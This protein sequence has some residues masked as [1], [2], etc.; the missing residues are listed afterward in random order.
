MRKIILTIFTFL[1]AISYS[2]TWVLQNSNVSVSLQKIFFVDSLHGWSVGNTGTI[3]RS[4]DGGANWI[5]ANSGVSTT[6]NGVHFINPSVGWVV[7]NGGVILKTTNGG[8]SW[9]SQNST[10]TNRLAN[11]FFTDSLNGW[12]NDIYFNI[13]KTTNSGVTWTQYSVG[14]SCGTNNAI[15]EFAFTST[16]NGFFLTGCGNISS[17]IAQTTNGGVTWN[18][19]AP[20]ITQPQA[21][22]FAP[23]KRD[24]YIFPATSVSG[25]TGLITSDSGAT[26]SLLP[27]AT[28]LQTTDVSC[29]SHSVAYVSGHY[30]NATGNVYKTTDAGQT[31]SATFTST[32]SKKNSVAFTDTNHGWCCDAD[33]NIWRWDNSSATIS[34]PIKYLCKGSFASIPFTVQGNFV[35][36]NIFKLYLSNQTG[37]FS[38]ASLIDSITTTTSGTFHPFISASLLNGTGYKLRITGSNPPYSHDYDSSITIETITGNFTASQT[39]LT[40]PQ[41]TAQ[42]NNSSVNANWNYTWL[43]GDSSSPYS[44]N[45]STVYHTYSDNGLFDVSLIITNAGGCSDTVTKSGYIYSTGIPTGVVNNFLDAI[46]VYPNPFSDNINVTFTNDTKTLTHVKLFNVTGEVVKQK[47]VEKQSGISSVSFNASD[48]TRGM[49]VLQITIDGQTINKKVEVQ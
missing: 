4:L 49:Y 16:S 32:T 8:N 12:C 10:T 39:L 26:W 41:S 1:S 15:V 43:F 24:G 28:G 34:T 44:S 22:S 25:N 37:N 6:L 9:S 11:V 20:S 46:N 27:T 31:W 29:I 40:Y 5:I 3:V 33:G 42:F 13:Y 30:G 7:G 36:G 45:N 17:N 35:N 23:N 21:I 47:I 19:L 2:Q 18:G 48:L 14:L 38:S